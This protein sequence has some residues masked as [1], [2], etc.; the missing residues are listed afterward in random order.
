M[1]IDNLA[2]SS[3]LD[4]TDNFIVFDC[5]KGKNNLYIICEEK[6]GYSC[7]WQRDGE[8]GSAVLEPYC[9]TPKS[10]RAWIFTCHSSNNESILRALESASFFLAYGD[11]VIISTE[12]PKK[13]VEKY[14]NNYQLWH[15][16]AAST[17]HK[18]DG[19]NVNCVACELLLSERLATDCN[20]DFASLV[21]ECG[22][23]IANAEWSP[24]PI[25]ADSKKGRDFPTHVLPKDL[26]EIVETVAE[27]SKVRNGLPATMLMGVLPAIADG[28]IT[29]DDEQPLSIYSLCLV[30]T[31]V[32][33]TTIMNFFRKPFFQW[34][35]EQEKL[36]L[37]E[38]K[39]YEK[40]KGTD[41][42]A[43]EPVKPA[44]IFKGST[45]YTIQGLIVQMLVSNQYIFMDEARS[46]FNGF[47]FK[48][49][50][51]EQTF[52]F[53][54]SFWSGV[55]A[56]YQTKDK[57]FDVR[58]GATLTLNLA[59]QHDGFYSIVNDSWFASGFLPRF[60]F[61]QEPPK[62][63]GGVE[64][65]L[66]SSAIKVD[67]FG[68]SC[69][70]RY[71]HT[72]ESRLMRPV[73]EERIIK[74][75]SQISRLLGKIEYKYTDMTADHYPNHDIYRQHEVYGFLCRSRDHVKRLACL[76]AVYDG[77]GELTAEYVDRAV[78]IFDYYLS[79]LIRL[80][81]INED[82]GENKK[83][84]DCVYRLS[85][86]SDNPNAPLVSL[87]QVQSTKIFRSS[88]NSNISIKSAE[89][90]EICERLQEFG[91]LKIKKKGNQTLLK[92]HPKYR[93]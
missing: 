5:E 30:P 34:D 3:S 39:D 53:L 22:G 59:M 66:P 48:N 2:Q 12:S 45:N 74:I 91:F 65:I 71:C 85:Q 56:S 33:K 58:H 35:K 25:L 11:R 29:S 17:A 27:A 57:Y 64:R 42:T 36:Y 61:H 77:I 16:H 38:K 21:E 28:Y 69:Y 8:H 31:G 6:G 81:K 9:G 68:D 70:K 14:E 92:L 49:D 50:Q 13:T 89:L 46:F 37:Q 88:S 55:P 19:Y 78:E 82:N 24:L 75:N 23:T 51:K 73:N 1:T 7:Q 84:L 43:V 93:P 44:R 83:M 18:F 20:I 54:S 10:D 76:M 86:D 67:Q 63:W 4:K 26:A 15:E 62:K 60:I 40:A 52:G 72:V 87:R 47:P 90:L 32:G 41:K 79:E 80:V